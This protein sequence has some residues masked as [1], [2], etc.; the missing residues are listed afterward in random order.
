MLEGNVVTVCPRA[1]Y[2][3]VRPPPRI[4][5]SRSFVSRSSL[6]GLIAPAP[7]LA[8]LTGWSTRLGG[9]RFDELRLQKHAEEATAEEP[10]PADDTAQVVV[11]EPTVAAQP[12]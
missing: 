12:N 6:R 11:D 10:L 5:H 3:Q 9:I 1:A 7:P 4:L 8:Q 2:T